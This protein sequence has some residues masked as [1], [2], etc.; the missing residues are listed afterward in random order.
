MDFQLVKGYQ[1]GMLIKIIISWHEKEDIQSLVSQI[2]K[3]PREQVN[4][5]A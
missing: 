5:R 1:P 3:K 4:Q 2:I